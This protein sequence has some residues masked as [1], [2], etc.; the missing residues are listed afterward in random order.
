MKIIK[1]LLILFLITGCSDLKDLYTLTFPASMAVDYKDNEYK[2]TF[3]IINPNSLSKPENESSINKGEIL[4]ANSSAKSIGEAIQKLENKMRMEIKVDHVNSLFISP[5][6]L[7]EKHFKE[8]LNYFLHD[9]Y[10]R[11]ATSLFINTE[12]IEDI[13]QVKHNIS[14]SPYFSLIAYN[15]RNKLSALEIP[16]SVLEIIK[17]FYSNDEISII[18]NLSIDQDSTLIT[19]GKEDSAKRFQINELTILN[20]RNAS[21]FF[22]E[23]LK[24]LTYINEK[25][26]NDVNETIAYNQ[27]G[28]NYTILHSKT[29]TTFKNGRYQIL[30]NTKL[31]FESCPPELSENEILNIINSNMKQSIYDTYKLLLE[32]DIDYLNLHDLNSTPVT[33]DQVDIIIESKLEL[34]N[35]YIE[36]GGIE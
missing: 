23:D 5:V 34:K 8:V 7:E 13:Y 2:V 14:S 20:H 36:H 17:T 19:E 22:I 30:L 12:S 15:S 4:I 33:I 21:T 6:I 1:Y 16:T 24:G 9:Q 26:N 3:Q 28:I 31:A 35:N 27:A 29:K 10:L 32:N 25:S 18:P 11:L